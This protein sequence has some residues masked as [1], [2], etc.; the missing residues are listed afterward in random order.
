MS[1]SE[2]SA[3]IQAVRTKIAVLGQLL[4][5][6]R[7]TDAAG[8]NISARVSN[9]ICITPRYSGQRRRW[10]LSAEEVLVTDLQGNVMHGEGA[11]SRESKVHL[12]VYADFP[13]A[14]AIIHA[15]PL[16]VLAF[17]VM[18]QP[19]P[20]VLEATLK[21]GVIGVTQFAPA[22]SSELASLVSEALRGQETRMKQQAAAVLTPWH[23]IF[24]VGCDLDSVFDAVER[25]ETNARLILMLRSAFG[26]A[27]LQESQQA[28]ARSVEHWRKS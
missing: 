18:R 1:S 12:R 11:I 25:I 14:R 24:C 20:P 9:H 2:L 27:A 3:E 19:I 26:E 5:E 4:Y 13:E 8:G 17:C 16:H 21:F 28:L 15:H 23:G 22:H 10:R 6:K 7:L